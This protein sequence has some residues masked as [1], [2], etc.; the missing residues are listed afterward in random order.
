MAEDGS[1]TGAG[2]VAINALGAML[3]AAGEALGVQTMLTSLES[4]L[5]GGGIVLRGGSIQEEG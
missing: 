2:A 1:G 4:S 5:S 3:T